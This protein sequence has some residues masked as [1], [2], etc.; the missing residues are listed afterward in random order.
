MLLHRTRQRIAYKTKAFIFDLAGLHEVVDVREKNR[1]EDSMGFRGKFDEHRR[2]QMAL[3]KEQGLIPSHKFLE[4]GCGPLTGGIPII[5][6]LEPGNYIGIDIRSSVL[7]LSWKEVG[8]AGL[9]AKNPRLI[10]S[11]SFGSSELADEKFDYIF[12]FSILFHLNEERLA[13]YFNTVRYRLKSQGVCLAN[14]NIAYDES[15]WL[16]FPFVKRTLQ[17]Y[18]ELATKEGLKMKCVGEERDLGF[19][20]SRQEGRNQVLSFGVG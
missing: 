19:R 11:S 16:E 15:T 7:D 3:L 20:L 2:F 10:C 6:Y 8:K 13:S 14:V 18:Q 12:S 5:E 4:I 17:Q 9:S 1:L